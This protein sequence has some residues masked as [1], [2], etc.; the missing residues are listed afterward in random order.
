MTNFRFHLLA[1]ALSL[2]PMTPVAASDSA[3]PPTAAAIDSATFGALRARAIGTARTSGRI[4]AIDATLDTPQTIFVGSAGGGVWRSKNGGTSFAPVFDAH[5]Q[6]IGALRIDPKNPQTIWVGTGE[7]NTRNSVS[8]GEGVYRSTDGG[9]S[10]TLMGLEG[11]ERIARVVINPK[12][13][14]EVFVC[15]TGRLWS[16]SND[17]GVYRTQDAGKN[18]QKVLHV[19]ARTGCSDLA[20]DPQNPGVLYAGLWSF[21]R[22]PDFFYSGGSSGGLFRSTDGGTTWQELSN[23]LPSGETGRVT[24]ALAPSNPKMIYAIIETKSTAL[25]RSADGGEHFERRNSDENISVRPFYFAELTVDQINPEKIFRPAL[26]LSTSEDGGKSFSIRNAQIHGDHHALWIHPKRPQSMIIGTD[27]G[28]YFSDDA[29]AQWRHARNLPVSQFYHVSVDDAE[30][31]NVYGGLQDNGSWMAPSRGHGAISNANWQNIGP[32]DGMWAWADPTDAQTIFSQFQGGK[33]FR[34]HRATG[35]IKVIS[36]TS[37]TQGVQLRRNWNSPFILAP[38]KALYVGTQYLH[39]SLDRGDNWQRISP[40]LTT[41]SKARQRQAN[42]GG[43]SKDNTSAEANSTIYTI[44]E[45]AKSPEVIWVGTDDGKAQLT[46]N[47]GTQWQDLTGNLPGLAK[48]AWVARIEASNFDAA[49]AWVVIDDHRRGDFRPQV[50]FTR[51]YGKSFFALDLQG[52]KGYAWVI[53]QDP[54]N[55]ELLYLGT[56]L[57]LYISLDAGKQWARFNENLPAVAVHDLVIHP[58]THDLIIAT[59]GRGV[60]IIDDLTPLRALSPTVLQSAVTLLPSRPAVQYIQPSRQEFP[61]SDE[62]YGENPADAAVI[63]FYQSKRH[64]FGDLKVNI[65]DQAGTLIDGVSADKRRGMVR[66]EWPTRLKPPRL[67]AATMAL[68]GQLIGPRV[69]EGNYRVE[70]IKDQ[71]KL[72]GSLTVVPDPR[73]PHSAL[74]RAEQQQLAMQ[75]YRDLDDLS[76]L[77]DVLADVS[78]RTELVALQLASPAQKQLRQ[79]AAK[80][81][82]LRKQLASSGTDGGYVSGEMQLRE[83]YG[84]LYIEISNYDGKPSAS[85]V[86][87]RAQLRAELNAHE[88]QA[89]QLVDNELAAINQLLRAANLPVIEVL[90]R[91]PSSTNQAGS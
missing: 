36:P 91:P 10:W 78:K 74:D 14:A 17:R 6:S 8:I 63:A 2:A 7:A 11:T 71:Q 9:E 40:D 21:R 48:G 25:Y 66:V 43:L 81:D 37:D 57:G 24:I 32:G 87:Q 38:S 79:H 1:I 12:N 31:Y 52:V 35:E 77:A 29:G 5:V 51:D 20:I 53:K 65:Y 15:A 49:Q 3:T 28:V 33:L 45:S 86:Q 85:Q 27:G 22:E 76:H 69:M 19:D 26:F 83:R 47:G 39:R 75:L 50:Y 89:K 84:E 42:S 72:T 54:V 80:F 64:F 34:V 16:D 68:Q 67:P 62:F 23:G 56:E 55:A 30:P 4:T 90:T 59:H 41:N 73:S 46:R 82:A 61:G 60:Y 58:R 88:T 44:A 13:S 70:L 18:W